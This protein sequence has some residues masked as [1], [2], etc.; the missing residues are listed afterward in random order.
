MPAI[1]APADSLTEEQFMLG[2]VAAEVELEPR[3][4]NLFGAF[5]DAADGPGEADG[6]D[7]PVDDDS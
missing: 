7:E 5:D 1:L 2:S 6:Q 4:V 3:R